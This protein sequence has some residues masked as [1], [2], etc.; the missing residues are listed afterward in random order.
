MPRS[1]SV[2]G[3]ASLVWVVLVLV[4]GAAVVNDLTAPAVTVSS[5]PS[6]V[7]G[8]VGAMVALVAVGL[9]AIGLARRRAWRR[10]GRQHLDLQ[11]EGGGMFSRA[12]LVGTDAG[13]S[14]RVRTVSR[15][16]L[17]GGTSNNST[18]YTVVEADLEAAVDEGLVV[19]TGD[20]DAWPAVARVNLSTV[21]SS[22]LLPAPLGPM[23]AA[24]T[25]GGTLRSM[26]HSAGLPS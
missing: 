9:G 17:G 10:V 24:I 25:P 20:A 22:V 11:P 13:R 26:S 7:L 3:G 2:Y 14:V 4:G 8:L 1:Q 15:N 12:D 5:F 19:A 23:M 21:F 16:N 18:T 6:G